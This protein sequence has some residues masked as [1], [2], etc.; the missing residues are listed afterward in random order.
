MNNTLNGDI[1]MLSDD[2]VTPF[3]A[4]HFSHGN[5]GRNKAKAAMTAPALTIEAR[6]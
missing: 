1:P 4:T 2:L 6:K 5:N 3:E